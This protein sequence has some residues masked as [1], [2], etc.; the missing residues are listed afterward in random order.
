MITTNYIITE[1][2]VN[3]VFVCFALPFCHF[4][5]QRLISCLQAGERPFAAAQGDM[6]CGQRYTKTYFTE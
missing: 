2:S 4:E 3:E 6:M 5:P 1:Y